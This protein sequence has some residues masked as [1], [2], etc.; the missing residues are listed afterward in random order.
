MRNLAQL[1][2]AF[3]KQCAQRDTMPVRYQAEQDWALRCRCWLC[4]TS[5]CPC[6]TSPN[7]T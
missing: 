6:R 4:N 2:I 1:F 5:L 3:A 7:Y